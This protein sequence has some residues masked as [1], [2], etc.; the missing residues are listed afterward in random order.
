MCTPDNAA[1]LPKNWPS[2][3]Y[4]SVITPD[5]TRISC[6][7]SGELD[8]VVLAPDRLTIVFVEVRYRRRADFGSAIESVDA[9]KRRKLELTALAWLQKHQACDSAVRFDVV[10]V[11]PDGPAY[12]LDWIQGAFELSD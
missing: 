7:V 10:G 5:S 9:P 4:S 1:L 3:F 12:S 11:Q 8:L 2:S 6:A